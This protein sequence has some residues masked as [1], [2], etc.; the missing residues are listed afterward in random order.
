[1]IRL[2]ELIERS[3]QSFLVVMSLAFICFVLAWAHSGPGAGHM[4]G[5]GMQANQLVLMCMAVLAAGSVMV[6]A[7]AGAVHLR[8][9]RAPRELRPM[10][11]SPDL[12]S[13]LL[14]SARSRA[15]PA[16]L[17]VFRR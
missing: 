3:G 17:Q 2:R 8:R 10:G 12:A 13:A 16:T 11:T 1:M 7:V 9:P 6:G 14:V 5:D 15:G 4:D